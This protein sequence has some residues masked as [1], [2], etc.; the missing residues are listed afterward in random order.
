MGKYFTEISYLLKFWY[1]FL[2][3]RVTTRAMQGYFLIQKRFSFLVTNT[4]RTESI[5]TSNSS[6]I[7][8][9][10]KSMCLFVRRKNITMH[11]KNKKIHSTKC[12]LSNNFMFILGKYKHEF[13]TKILINILHLFIFL[14]NN[15]KMPQICH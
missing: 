13:Q 6:A 3:R 1:G 14:P 9:M 4:H 2:N 15:S 11:S 7:G 12:C 10:L 5:L 8:I